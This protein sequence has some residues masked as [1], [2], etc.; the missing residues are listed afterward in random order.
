[1]SKNK[2]YT[3]DTIDF[4]SL[5]KIND[6]NHSKT[7]LYLEKAI[8]ETGFLVLKN[9]PIPFQKCKKLGILNENSLWRAKRA[10]I[11]LCLHDCVALVFTSIILQSHANRMDRSISARNLV[12]H[13]ICR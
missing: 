2:K 7:M 8:K 10:Q 11:K 9:S 6:E 4:N 13:M 12:P 5:V 3:I 1:M